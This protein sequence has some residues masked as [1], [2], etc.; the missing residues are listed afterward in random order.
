MK[1]GAKSWGLLQGSPLKARSRIRSRPGMLRFLLNLNGRAPVHYADAKRTV[2][3]RERRFL[4]PLLAENSQIPSAQNIRARK[5]TY[6]AAREEVERP[7]ERNLSF[8][9]DWILGLG[10]VCA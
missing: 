2:D 9:S 3:L 8:P 5:R 6:D 1:A 4:D 10:P 7:N